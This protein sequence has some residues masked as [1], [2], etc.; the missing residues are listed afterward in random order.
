MPQPPKQ[1]WQRLSEKQQ[2]EILTEL[3]NICQEITYEHIRTNNITTLGS[4]SNNLYSTVNIASNS[5][6]S[7]K[8][9]I[10]VCT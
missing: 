10:A 3:L 8:S 2:N 1:V 4:Q 5:N 7:R 6:Q 9:K